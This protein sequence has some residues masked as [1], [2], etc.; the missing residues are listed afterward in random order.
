MSKKSTQDCVDQLKK[1]IEFRKKH[2][3]P[4]DTMGCGCNS[5]QIDPKTERFQTLIS[6]MLSSQTKDQITSEAVQNLQKMK[7]GLNAPNLMN[8]DP[9]VVLEC[10]KRVGFAQRKRE[11]IIEAA[12]KC[13]AEYDDDIPKTLDELT[14]FKG[15]GIKMATLAMMHCW[16]EN[17]GIGVDV[18]VH[19][20]SNLLGWIK[21][22]TPEQS[23]TALQKVFPQELWGEINH[24]LV[25][26]GQA[27]CTSKKPKCDICPIK[28]TCRAYQGAESS[29]SESEES[30]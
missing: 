27:Y 30:D 8:A 12:K 19:R 1:I 20:I 11:Y 28:D 17:I 25:G 14:A 26:F 2:E 5:E 4:V 29:E 7:G 9:T 15:V 23:E 16:H 21:T 18:H 13:H 6:L 10:I 22:K 24:A 3:A